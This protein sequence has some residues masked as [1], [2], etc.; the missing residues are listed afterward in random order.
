MTRSQTDF[1]G[2]FVGMN[3]IPVIKARSKDTDAAAAR[4]VVH[5]QATLFEWMP[6]DEQLVLDVLGLEG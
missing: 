6:A 3:P 1:A 5:H 4:R 2:G